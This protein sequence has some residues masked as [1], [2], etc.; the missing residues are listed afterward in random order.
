MGDLD[1]PDNTFWQAFVLTGTRHSWALV[2]P[3]GVADNGGLVA[4]LGAARVVV[5]VEASQLLGFSPVAVTDDD[6]AQWSPGV[7]PAPLAPVPDSLA[8]T[9]AHHLLALLGKTG[10]SIV[11]SDDDALSGTSPLATLSS[12]AAVGRSC[13][14]TALTT[15]GFGPASQALAGGLCEGSARVGIFEHSA[16]GWSLVGPAAP[17]AAL[18]LGAS[19]R[20]SVNSRSLDTEVLRLWTEGST[21][22]ALAD[23][24]GGDGT[25]SL[26]RLSWSTSGAWTESPVFDIPPTQRLIATGSGQDGSLFVLTERAGTATAEVLSASGS[27]WARL[28]ALPA[29]TAT[30]AFAGGVTYALGV[31]RA[32]LTVYE[33]SAKSTWDPKQ[34]IIVPIQFGSSS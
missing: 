28:P 3:E 19:H 20:S 12:L 31:D 9:T 8:T 34:V 5:G 13:K 15:V 17:E 2:T 18:S 23:V 7:L 30:L 14:L 26:F 6:G 33:L 11:M 21:V 1:Q 24:V 22:M 32:V 4:S 16:K 27:S 29:S 10:T 25:A